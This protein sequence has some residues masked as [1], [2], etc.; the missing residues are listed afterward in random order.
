MRLPERQRRRFA[1]SQVDLQPGLLEELNVLFS[2]V[3]FPILMNPRNQVAAAKQ[4][5]SEAHE[6][7]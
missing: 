7:K 3:L 4:N 5:K 1:L 6:T 2:E